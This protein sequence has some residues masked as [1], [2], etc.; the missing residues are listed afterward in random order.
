EALGGL[1]VGRTTR[2]HLR[3]MYYY[4]QVDGAKLGAICNEIR[5][6]HGYDLSWYLATDNDHSAYFEELYPTEEDWSVI[7]DLAVF[8]SLR[9]RGDT[10]QRLRKIHH[11]A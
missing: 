5:L 3:S 2:P 6:R 1:F 4:A 7:S 11:W 10:C 9:T 8:E